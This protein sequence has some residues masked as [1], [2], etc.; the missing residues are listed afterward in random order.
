VL[1]AF[2]GSY[3]IRRKLREEGAVGNARIPEKATA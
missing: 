1:T 3:E 2:V